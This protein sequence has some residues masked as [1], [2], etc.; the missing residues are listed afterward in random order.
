MKIP[1]A[2]IARPA[3]LP[4]DSGRAAAVQAVPRVA[5]SEGVPLVQRPVSRADQ[6]PVIYLRDRYPATLTRLAEHRYAERAVAT[7]ESVQ[8]LKRRDDLRAVSGIDDFA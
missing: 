4:A 5:D 3:L 8:Q 2:S 1:G 6:A 7:Y